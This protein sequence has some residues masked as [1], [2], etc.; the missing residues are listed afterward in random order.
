MLSMWNLVSRITGFLRV[1]A[2]G[3]ALG[4]TFLGN[5]Y[6]SANLVSNILFE[7]LA[8][9]ILSSVL[10]PTFVRHLAGGDRGGA[11]GLAGA[12]LGLLGLVLGPIVL[13][14][15]LA[16]EPIMRLVTITVDNPALREQ[17]IVL[18]AFFLWFFLP[19]ILLYALGAVST[20]LLHADHRFAAPAIAPVL[21]NLVVTVTMVLF[22]IVRDEAPTLEL[23]L[24]QKLLLALGTTSGVLAMTLAPV[25][26]ARR[27]GFVLRPSLRAHRDELAAMAGRGAWA[28]GH[29]G[30][31]QAL[32]AVTLVLANRVEGGAVAYQIAF[33]FFLLPYAL[34]CNPI[35]T[36]LFPRLADDAHHDDRAA[37]ATHLG[38]GLNQLGFLVLPA[39]VLLVVVSRPLVEVLAFGALSA[40]PELVARTLAGYAVGLIGYSAFQLLTRASYADEDTRTPTV[41]NFAMT[42]SGAAL[43]LWWSSAAESTDRVASLGLAHSVVQLGGA[44]A[45][46]VVVSRRTPGGL[47]VRVPMARAL[48]ASLCAGVAAWLL[49]ENLD[50]HGRIGAGVTTAMAGLAGITIY[51]GVQFALGSP[52]LRRRAGSREEHV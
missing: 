25:V 46:L 33:T 19:Q 44:L 20:G 41:V 2:T 50:L 17:E 38:R 23:P 21:N 28:A 40:N 36:T 43:M 37:F 22:W 9:G 48:S 1:L 47:G 4:A 14:G 39:S 27:S 11:S 35:L 42:A 3:A 6:Q 31:T 32:L 16:G 26:A 52:E 8:A 51:V 45:L 15:V 5:T 49:I 13:L 29:L 7:L 30:L 34:V 18:G 10:V 12:V 24:G